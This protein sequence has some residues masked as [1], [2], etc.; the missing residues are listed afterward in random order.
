MTQSWFVSRFVELDLAKTDDS[1]VTCKDI[2]AGC[3]K[4]HLIQN[5]VYKMDKLEYLRMSV[6]CQAVDNIIEFFFFHSEGTRHNQISPIR[7]FGANY[8]RWHPTVRCPLVRQDSNI[9]PA[10]LLKVFQTQ[11]LL[12][13]LAV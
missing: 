7:N 5:V 11:C 3:P 9:F 4:A 10:I 2:P 6:R 13:C 8:M 1:G 12:P